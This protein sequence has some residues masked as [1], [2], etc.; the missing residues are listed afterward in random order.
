MRRIFILFGILI[1]F[2]GIFSGNLAGLGPS[3]A[4]AFNPLK[5]CVD[6]CVL[7]GSSGIAKCK[8]AQCSGL[9]KKSSKAKCER[10]CNKPRGLLEYCDRTCKKSQLCSGSKA[11]KACL[12]EKCEPIRK[13]DIHGYIKCKKTECNDVCK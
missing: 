2:T 9:K 13:S 6:K 4:L 5:H 11:M 1:G 8:K 12:L 3:E 7:S 10:R